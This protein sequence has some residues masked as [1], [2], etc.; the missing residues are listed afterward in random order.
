M[1]RQ[2]TNCSAAVDLREK[3]DG[4]G[5]VLRSLKREKWDGEGEVLSPPLMIQRP[6]PEK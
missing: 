4:E 6:S 2:G 5:E 1:R 3:W